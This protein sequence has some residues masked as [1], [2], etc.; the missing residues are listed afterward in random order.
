[1]INPVPVRGFSEKAFAV[2]PDTMLNVN[3]AL[4]TSEALTWSTV[5]P[6]GVDSARESE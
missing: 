6:T 4:S 3:T 2:F 5:V 1:M